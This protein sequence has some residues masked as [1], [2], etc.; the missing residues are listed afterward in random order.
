MKET[1]AAEPFPTLWGI[2]HLFN[3]RHA[4]RLSA[5]RQF[6]F[7]LDSA[8]SRQSPTSRPNNRLNRRADNSPA[9][10]PATTPPLSQAQSTPCPTV[11]PR[12]CAC[13]IPYY[14]PLKSQD[15]G[16]AVPTVGHQMVHERSIL[17][18]TGFLTVGSGLSQTRLRACPSAFRHA[19]HDCPQQ[20]PA[21]FPL[22][23]PAI[24]PARSHA[25]SHYNPGISTGDIPSSTTQ[26]FMQ[27]SSFDPS[28]FPRLAQ[29]R[30]KRGPLLI[31]PCAAI[32][33]QVGP[34]TDHSP[35]TSHP[36][37]VRD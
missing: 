16:Q 23:I 28:D 2:Y 1:N 27:G 11:H 6:R 35:P 12:R 15:L 7:R 9:C 4:L 3:I 5:D 17:W 18:P 21:R 37:H 24:V 29:A 14:G 10:F 32:G 26:W 30:P 20:D 8:I 36:R 13:Q 19:S 25:L 34:S 33:L 22:T 31:P